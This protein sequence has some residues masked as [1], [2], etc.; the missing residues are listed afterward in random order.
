MNQLEQ[1]EQ[2]FNFKYPELYKQLHVDGMLNWGEF[3]PNWH[4]VYWNKLKNNPPL[5]LFGDDFE[6]L[7]FNR[8][9]EE[10]EAFKDPEDYRATKP[11][12]QFIPFGQTGGGD[13]YVFQFDKQ[14]GDNIPVTL[15][16]HDSDEA[17]VLT[18]NLQD[19]IF[20][21]LLEA[22]T[23]IDK[24]SRIAEE[25]LGANCANIL[26]SHKPYLTES[27][28]KKLTEVYSRQLFE[29]KYKVSNGREYSMTG[30]ISRDE[31][32]EMLL[33]EIGFDDFE[34]EFVYMG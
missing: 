25:D 17:I 23:D 10:I 16:S 13:L 15:V 2:K 3:G 9:I 7:D 27:Q 19:F 26:K 5:L 28:V 24:Y 22:V 32:K 14:S 29:Y 18:K 12:F 20:L 34:K 30:L 1:I 8:V 21:Q 11:E 4:A 31:F 33:Q 6:L